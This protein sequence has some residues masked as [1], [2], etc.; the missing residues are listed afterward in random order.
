MDH[1]NDLPHRLTTARSTTSSSKTFRTGSTSTPAWRGRPRDQHSFNE[2]E[3]LGTDG[4]VQQVHRS[5]M[6]LRYIYKHQMAL[7]LRAAGFSRFQIHGD[8]DRR[9]LTREDDPLIVEA[10]KE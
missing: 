1:P 9:P 4:S 2:L 3:L 7:L 5:E 8:F 6:S 10:W